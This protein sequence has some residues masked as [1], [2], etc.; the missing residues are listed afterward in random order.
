MY[1]KVTRC[2]LSIARY[3]FLYVDDLGQYFKKIL[4]FPMVY[5][6]QLSL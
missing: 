5:L 3:I 2:H 1:I 6:H 4:P